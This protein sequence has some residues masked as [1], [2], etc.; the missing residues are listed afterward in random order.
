MNHQTYVRSLCFCLKDDI[1]FLNADI[2]KY[3]ISQLKVL[4]AV[5]SL[6]IFRLNQS[7]S[8]CG[9]YYIFRSFMALATISLIVALTSVYYELRS[10]IEDQSCS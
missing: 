10:V 9:N 5:S 7:M 8:K 6:E 2:D 1:D 4:A 3:E